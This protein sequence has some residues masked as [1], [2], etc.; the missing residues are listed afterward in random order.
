MW[1][2]MRTIFEFL[3]LS[4]PWPTASSSPTSLKTLRQ[5]RACPWGRTLPAVINRG[6][7]GVPPHTPPQSWGW[8]ALG[9]AR[10]PEEHSAGFNPASSSFRLE[11]ETEGSFNTFT[12]KLQGGLRPPHPCTPVLGPPL[13][14]CSAPH[15]VASPSAWGPILPKLPFHG[16][17]GEEVGLDVRPGFPL[18]QEVGV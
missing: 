10:G 6:V 5:A 12:S 16:R 15:V 18:W 11:S 17:S 9:A 7:L 3:L 14:L 2:G 13:P 8:S 1:G 4:L